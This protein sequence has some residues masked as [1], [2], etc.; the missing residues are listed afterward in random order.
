MYLLTSHDKWFIGQFH[1]NLE[2]NCDEVCPVYGMI[3][4]AYS[5]TKDEEFKRFVNQVEG[6]MSSPVNNM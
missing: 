4:E 6:D 2:H 3:E 1:S 5:K